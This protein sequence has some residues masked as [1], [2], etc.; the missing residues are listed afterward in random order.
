MI[1][2]S[3][4][5]RISKKSKRTSAILD[6]SLNFQFEPSVNLP[7]PCLLLRWLVSALVPALVSAYEHACVCLCAR[8]KEGL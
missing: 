3:L 4:A 7:R 6:G 8:R 1:F 5:Y 2:S